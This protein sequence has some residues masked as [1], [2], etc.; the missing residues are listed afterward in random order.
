MHT[1]FTRIFYKENIYIPKSEADEALGISVSP[2]VL[3]HG[4]ECINEKDYNTLVVSSAELWERN[5]RHEEITHVTTLRAESASLLSILP[6]KKIF[7]KDLDLDAEYQKDLDAA[8]AQTKKLPNRL[9]NYSQ[10]LQAV[11]DSNIININ[12]LKSINLD[13]QCMTE[14][15]ENGTAQLTCYVVGKGY[16]YRVYLEDAS[17]D[18]SNPE[19]TENG[20][21]IQREIH[22]FRW[23]NCV[24]KPYPT[25]R[26]F[27]EHSIFDNIVWCL[28]NCKLVSEWKDEV[29]FHEDGIEMSA[30]L[31]LIVKLFNKHAFDKIT[32][33]EGTINLTQQDWITI[34]E[35]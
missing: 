6:M 13:V 12:K 31:P 5:M 32:F 8:I 29:C 25:S 9:K 4:I 21:Q 35:E 18:W 27:R 33:I 23:E 16:F 17:D 11:N 1:E 10:S 30:E 28:E 34:Q 2:T 20:V 26:D 19:W 15:S 22:D 7:I 14:I 24:I 3:I